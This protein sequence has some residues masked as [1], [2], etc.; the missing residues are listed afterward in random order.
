MCCVWWLFSLWDWSEYLHR[1]Y[2]NFQTLNFCLF[3]WCHLFPWNLLDRFFFLFFFM[4]SKCWWR[5]QFYQ[6]LWSLTTALSQDFIRGSEWA[7]S[8]NSNEW[9]QH[10]RAIQAGRKPK[11]E[12]KNEKDNKSGVVLEEQTEIGQ[13]RQRKSGPA[14]NSRGIDRTEKEVKSWKERGDERE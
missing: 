6:S 12:K 14:T 5:K 8:S 2:T 3:G 11:L 4:S 10:L 7:S 13:K 1:P 9:Q